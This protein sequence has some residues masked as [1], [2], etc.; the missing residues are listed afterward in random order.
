M[1]F[2]LRNNF[3]IFLF[4]GWWIFRF[5]P[6]FGA[7]SEGNVK[8]GLRIRWTFGLIICWYTVSSSLIIQSMSSCQVVFVWMFWNL[9][10]NCVFET[11]RKK[12][13]ILWKTTISHVSVLIQL[14]AKLKTG[15]IECGNQTL[16]LQQI[17]SVES[18]WDI[19][20]STQ[21]LINVIYPFNQIYTKKWKDFVLLLL[22]FLYSICCSNHFGNGVYEDIHCIGMKI[23]I[24]WIS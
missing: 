4:G 8:I 22:C 24:L 19:Y 2:T 15:T 12:K 10:M 9:E 23:F 3:V 1:A 16:P 13:K 21:C 7:L 17:V 18:I 14:R 5:P 11:K 20:H 6:H